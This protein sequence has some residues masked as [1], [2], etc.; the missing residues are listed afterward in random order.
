MYTLEE[1]AAGLALL[2]EHGDFAEMDTTSDR[3]A[4]VAQYLD[5][6]QVD[7]GGRTVDPFPAMPQH[8]RTATTT[9]LLS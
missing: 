6:Y 7:L 1:Q 2:T 3:S 8:T 9:A 4:W 5:W